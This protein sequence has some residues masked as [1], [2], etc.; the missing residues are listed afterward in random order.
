MN[1]ADDNAKVILLILGSYQDASITRLRNLKR[2]L[3]GQ[4]WTRCYLVEDFET[5]R[6][7]EGED[8]DAY[9]TRKSLYW[10]ERS[11]ACIFVF[12]ARANNESVG[13]ELKH[14][15]DHLPAKLETTLVAVDATGPYASTLMRGHIQR[16]Q[17]DKHATV[18]TFNDEDMLYQASRNAALNF[19][20]ILSPILA[21][22]PD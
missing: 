6:I 3:N 18:T 19:L 12:N 8:E 7:R 9:L 21:L 20:D 11:D 4:G 5:P 16:L 1:G 17:R 10:I 22:R 15:S 13:Y 2:H 14:A